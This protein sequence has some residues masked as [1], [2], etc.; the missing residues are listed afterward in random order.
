MRRRLDVMR[1]Q[2]GSVLREQRG[3]VLLETAMAVPVL[4]AVAV[5]LVWVVSLGA[6]YVRALD[7]AQTAARQVARGVPAE[8]AH[9]ESGGSLEVTREGDIVRAVVIRRVVAPVPL[10][11]GLGIDVRAEAVALSETGSVP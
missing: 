3:S 8:S 1:E 4:V 9:H 6:V 2:R 5:A 10:L 11:D 7:T